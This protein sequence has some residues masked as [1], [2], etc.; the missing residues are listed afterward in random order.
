MSPLDMIKTII[1]DDKN[2]PVEALKL[3]A[4]WEVCD[5]HYTY[6]RGKSIDGAP[7]VEVHAKE[8]KKK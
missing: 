8:K 7:F 6:R 3:G 5:R 4:I 2:Y 1:A